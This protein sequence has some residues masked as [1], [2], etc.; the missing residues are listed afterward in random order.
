MC[1]LTYLPAHKNYLITSSRDEG[2]QRAHAV[3]PVFKDLNT[4]KV[5]MPQD[6]EGGGTWAATDHG[7]NTTCLLNGA[8]ENHQ[9][10]PPYRKSRGLVVLDTFRYASIDDFARHYDFDQIEPFTLVKA[11]QY[12]VRRLYEVRWDGQELFKKEMDPMRPHIWSSV[13]LY[14]VAMREKRR[15]W[16]SQWLA[17]EPAFTPEN[18]MH[19]HIYGGEGNPDLDF[20]MKRGET[21]QTVSLSCIAVSESR[22]RFIY[23]DFS[24]SHTAEEIISHSSRPS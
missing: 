23:L 9:R 3:F 24:D 1:T 16:F 8:F 6:P 22:S 5:L 7:G 15:Q 20:K 2:T 11:A 13:T 17:E 10:Q 12:P 19:F 18:I 14:D 4:G 21:L